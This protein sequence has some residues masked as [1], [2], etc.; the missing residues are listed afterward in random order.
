M[1][2]AEWVLLSPR[3]A[4]CAPVHSTGCSRQQ[5]QSSRPSLHRGQLLLLR[6]TGVWRLPVCE[7]LIFLRVE[8]RCVEFRCAADILARVSSLIFSPLFQGVLPCSARDK[9]TAQIWPCCH[10]SITQ[11]CSVGA[12]EDGCEAEKPTWSLAPM[13][14]RR[15][16]FFFQRRFCARLIFARVSSGSLRPL[17]QGGLRSLLGCPANTCGR[18]ASCKSRVL[19]RYAD[20]PFD[21][22]KHTPPLLA[23]GNHALTSAS[24][25]ATADSGPDCGLELGA[26]AAVALLL[27]LPL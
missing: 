23:C 21:H 13:V 1:P 12:P 25:V 22:Q 17:F 8:R 9:D 27:P 26:A 18:C 2:A 5:Q 24:S 7:R 20:V 4:C 3:M 19:L 10:L 16:G 6:R 15:S 11:A 14:A